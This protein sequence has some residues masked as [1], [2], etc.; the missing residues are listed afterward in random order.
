MRP[1]AEVRRD[2]GE[3]KWLGFYTTLD[4]EVVR[5]CS[6]AEL[7]AGGLCPRYGFRLMGELYR[8]RDTINHG[9]GAARERALR[10]ALACAEAGR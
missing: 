8:W 2:A 7:R 4:G 6:A 1:K 9:S 5:Y 10:E 3:H